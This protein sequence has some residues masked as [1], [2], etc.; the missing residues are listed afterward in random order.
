MDANENSNN[1][2]N[3]KV[4]Q[5]TYAYLCDRKN[6]LLHTI[7]QIENKV[8]ST[9]YFSPVRHYKDELLNVNKLLGMIKMLLDKQQ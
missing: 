5:K 3:P 4:I 7:D 8:R 2:S 9:D 6:E 1:Y